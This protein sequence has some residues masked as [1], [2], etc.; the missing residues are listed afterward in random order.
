MSRINNTITSSHCIK[1]AYE[2]KK[3][4]TDTLRRSSTPNFYTIL[5]V[6]PKF[7][8]DITQEHGRTKRPFY[9]KLL[10]YRLIKS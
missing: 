1:L 6:C 5:G 4:K 2:F 3:P 7:E 8:A 9:S 10:C